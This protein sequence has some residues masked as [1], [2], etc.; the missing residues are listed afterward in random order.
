MRMGDGGEHVE[1]QAHARV[2]VE[3]CGIA[4]A[5]DRLAVDVLEHEVRLAAAATPASSRRAM[6]GCV[7]RA[8]M[9]LRAGSAR[10]PSR[11]SSAGFSSLTAT[12][13][14]EAPVAAVREPDGAHA[15]LRRAAGRACSCRPLTRERSA[16]STGR[17][18]AAVEEAVALDRRVLRE[19]V[20][21]VVGDRVARSRR[22]SA[23]RSRAPA[24]RAPAT[25]RA[26]GSACSQRALSNR[27]FT[28]PA[29]CRAGTGAPCSSRAAP[30]ARRCPRIAAISANEKPQK[31]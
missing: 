24:R 18:G 30:C 26:A 21:Q 16:R 15:A 27:P 25:R 13:A 8:R 31:N 22:S 12:C 7:S 28:A 14:L 23:R 5:V 3:A 2:D 29:V 17:S 20:R 1:E 6:F 19:E 4:P 11:P 10:S 9:R